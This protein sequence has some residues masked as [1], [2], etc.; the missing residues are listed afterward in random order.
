MMLATAMT[1]YETVILSYYWL[2]LLAMMAAMIG[3]EWWL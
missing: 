3:S 1:G 2:G